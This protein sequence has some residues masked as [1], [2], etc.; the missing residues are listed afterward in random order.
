MTHADIWFFVV[1][2]TIA[3]A[4]PGPV[5]GTLVAQILARRGAIAPFVAGIVLGNSLWLAAAMFGLA[6]VAVRVAVVFVVV[7]WLG[8]LYLVFVAWK[9]WTSDPSVVSVR[10]IA[11]PG[12][13]AGVALT[14]G[15]PKAVV[16]FSAVLPQAFDMTRLSLAQAPLILGL[17]LLIDLTV[18]TAYV[19]AATR[20]RAL[21]RSPRHLRAV[22]RSAAGVMFGSAALI[23]SRR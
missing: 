23:A 13:L 18:Q 21:I 9:L 17:G 6:A 8:V 7:K 11:E 4:V 19:I 2:F 20:A 3:A 16:F 1:P 12:M 22:N 5:Q 10:R 14:L 15:N